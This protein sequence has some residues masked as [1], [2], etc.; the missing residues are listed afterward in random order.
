L[1]QGGSFEQQ[2]R[3]SKHECLKND[4]ARS[5]TYGA[6]AFAAFVLRA[7]LG[8]RASSFDILA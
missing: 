7:S 1:D 3:M 5:T 8:I 2:W 6:R 4:E